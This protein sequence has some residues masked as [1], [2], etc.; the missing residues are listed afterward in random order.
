MHAIALAPRMDHDDGRRAPAH[1]PASA[2]AVTAAGSRAA[3]DAR[4]ATAL[5]ARAPT[6]ARH[7]WVELSPLVRAVLRRELGPGPDE[8]DLCQEVFL[9]FFRR[10]DQ[11]RDPGA[12]RGFV[13]A[14]SL[15]VARNQRRRAQVRRCV[16]LTATGDAP[17]VAGVEPSFE[18]RQILGRLHHLLIEADAEDRSLFLTR[19]VD[20][21][22]LGTIAAMAGCRVGAVKG[23]L[24]RA[25][26]RL[27]ARMRRDDVLAP[28]A[29]A[30]AAAVVPRTA[31]PGRVA[32]HGRTV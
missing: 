25:V 14:I 26:H 21:E 24:A 12:L 5:M 28:H 23:R 27:S 8:M 20:H 32:R 7:A 1:A 3:A 2:A 4:L 10:I 22:H 9:R 15:G 11:L 18:A 30:L 13:V 31:R 17:A 16:S 6:A 19:Y 29:A